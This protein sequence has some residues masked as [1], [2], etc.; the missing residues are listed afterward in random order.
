MIELDVRRGH[1]PGGPELR[2]EA[3]FPLR[4][5]PWEVALPCWR[6]GR[7]ELGNFAQYVLS[8]EG[9]GADGE[10]VRLRKASLHRWQVPDGV[11]RFRWR[12]HAGILNAGSTY[13]GEE[14]LYLNPVNWVLF[15]PDRLG[16]GYRLV[17]SDV[18]EGWEVA[19]ALPR[20]PDGVW[21]ARDLQHLA[22][23]PVL[24]APALWH[25]EYEEAGSVF[26]VW[27][28]GAVPREQ[29]RFIADHQRF[30]ATMIAAFNGRFPEP[31]YHFLY[32]F[33][34]LD[35]RH[36]V[37]HA[38]STVIVLGPPDRV[39]TE[40]GY[41][42]LISI[43]CH[44]L[45]HTWNVK[46]L[47]PAEWLPYDF[48][49]AV[50]SRLGY[51]AEG[52]TTYMGDLFLFEAGCIDRQAWDRRWSEML[53]RHRMNP[54]RLNLSVADSGFDT[55]L[56]GYIPGVPGRKSS[57]YIEGAVLAM[58]CDVRI[59]QVTAGRASLQ[60]AIALLHDRLVPAGRGLT[61]DLYWA[62]L[63][64]VAGRPGTTADLRRRFCD[65]CEDT[66]EE[67]AAAMAWMG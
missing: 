40:E 67:V 19:T 58:L 50:P 33:P 65:G 51:V 63:D 37:E 26:H 34:E 11:A 62:T 47:R 46:R 38:D 23:A 60:T 36:G 35:V 10:W 48:E 59:M 43:A 15:D 16:L 1:G 25:R 66:A 27:A 29:K 42:E 3:V 32:L 56:D 7:Y 9:L 31:A 6:P 57:I 49:R 17:L 30:T 22:D 8:M 2:V 44:E 61:E 52:V 39:A 41:E 45:Y 53:R 4:E 14:V 24:A 21:V 55:W 5:G 12:F 20:D 54:G 13:V 28:Y 18:P 64:E